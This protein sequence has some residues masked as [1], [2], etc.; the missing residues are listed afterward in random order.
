MTAQHKTPDLP[1]QLSPPA[2]LVHRILWVAHVLTIFAFAI[3][4][5]VQERPATP[6]EALALLPLLAALALGFAAASLFL[7][8]VL[9]RRRRLDYQTTNLTRY[10]F[11][12]GVAVTGLILGFS[13]ADLRYPFAFLG[14]A[15]LLILIQPPSQDG[16]KRHRA[17]LHRG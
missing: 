6:D 1:E 15:G 2:L 3:V 10:A 4:L 5:T 11:A 7:A 8:P 17:D 16:Y 13:G 12:E 14:V 9:A